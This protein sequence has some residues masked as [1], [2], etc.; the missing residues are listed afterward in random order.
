MPLILEPPL[1]AFDLNGRLGQLRR[2]LRTITAVAGGAGVLAVILAFVSLATVTD[3]LIHWRAT[4]RALF[5]IGGIVGL[6]LLVRRW[7]IIPWRE[8]N[9][10]LSLA[11]KVEAAAPGVNEALASAVEFA[12]L[13]DDPLAGSPQLRHATARYAVRHTWAF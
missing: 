9:D 11:R 8:C 4:F 5:L 13:P 3:F 10:G 12:S 6:T 2:R 7:L 1:P